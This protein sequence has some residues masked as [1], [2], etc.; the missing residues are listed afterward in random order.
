[1]SNALRILALFPPAM[2]VTERGRALWQCLR[3]RALRSWSRPY[4]YGWLVLSDQLK[5]QQR[6]LMTLRAS[7][8]LSEDGR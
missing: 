7:A 3:T 4:C 8:A 1:M 2:P 6:H 5:A